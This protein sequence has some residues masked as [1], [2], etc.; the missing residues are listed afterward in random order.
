MTLLQSLRKLSSTFNIDVTGP[1]AGSSQPS[2]ANLNTVQG[3]SEL[4]LFRIYGK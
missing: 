3:L 4:S 1:W 2:A